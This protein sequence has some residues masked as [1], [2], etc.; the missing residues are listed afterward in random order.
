MENIEPVEFFRRG[1]VPESGSDP[2]TLLLSF[3]NQLEV[4]LD[5]LRFP[6]EAESED[7]SFCNGTNPSLSRWPSII[8]GK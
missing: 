2:V 1:L 3:L 4:E 6:P 8:W 7:L 5:R